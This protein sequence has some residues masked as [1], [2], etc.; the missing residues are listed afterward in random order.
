[1]NYRSI[2]IVC[3]ATL[4]LAVSGWGQA[5]GKIAFL[6]YREGPFDV[7]TMNA[8]GSDPVNLTK[9]QN[10]DSPAWS[11][12][13]TRIAYIDLGADYSGS[14]VWVMDADGGNPQQLTDEPG[15]GNRL[16]WSE[17]GSSIYSYVTGR[18]ELFVVALDGSG[19]S[20]VEWTE[21]AWVIRRQRDL[22]GLSPD[23]TKRAAV[24]LPRDDV[25]GQ[26]FLI[27]YNASEDKQI[28][29]ARAITL[30]DQPNVDLSSLDRIA[31]FYPLFPLTW[32]PNGTRVAFSSY[33]VRKSTD[34]SYDYSYSLSTGEIW[35]VD[36]DGGNLVN[37]TN[38][39]GGDYPAWQ[40]V[41]PSVAATSVEVQSWGRIKALLSTG[42]R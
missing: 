34:T 31:W 38:D 19:S 14:D 11:P 23:E 24:V 22:R 32:A 7:W 12:D 21:G 18:F 1:M 36:I 8:D 2:L 26:A 41:S 27:I 15:L 29:A 37:L 39:L 17:D 40:P 16:F 4:G 20:P 28:T 42:T 13:G 30:S 6:S 10:C 35:V 33:T 5:D 25:E 9:G 3:L